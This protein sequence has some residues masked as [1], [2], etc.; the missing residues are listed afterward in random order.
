MIIWTITIF[1]MTSLFSP[2]LILLG[3]FMLMRLLCFHRERSSWIIHSIRRVWGIIVQTTRRV[4]L[5]LR[6]QGH[7]LI[8]IFFLHGL[9]IGKHK[10]R[11]RVIG[12]WWRCV[13][14]CRRIHIFYVSYKF[15]HGFFLHPI[16]HIWL[17]SYYD[18]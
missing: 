16:W 15:I 17:L 12:I 8:M 6:Y 3:I 7:F 9:H 4:L 10:G 1:D 2:Y 5:M 13:M 14:P 18:I 11:M